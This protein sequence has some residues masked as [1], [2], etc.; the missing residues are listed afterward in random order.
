MDRSISREDWEEHVAEDDARGRDVHDLKLAMFG[1]P[2]KPETVREAVMPTMTR[3]NT[4]M[5]VALAIGRGAVAL[6]VGLGALL[7]ILKTMGWL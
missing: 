7:G 5:D 6:L 2:E 3:L 1:D 4:Y